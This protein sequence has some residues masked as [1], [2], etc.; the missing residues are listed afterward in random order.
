MSFILDALKKSESER[1]R[2]VGPSL[3]DVRVVRR[4]NSERPWWVIAVAALL[5]VNLGVLL[6]VLIRGWSAKPDTTIQQAAAA[7]QSYSQPGYNGPPPTQAPQQS[8]NAGPQ[9][10]PNYAGQPARQYQQPPARQAYQPNPV[11]T[12][13]SVRS[14]ADEAG[15]YQEPYP[16]ESLSPHLA[17]AARVPEGAPM[18]RQIEPPAVAPLPSG[19]VLAAKTAAN[20]PPR[21]ALV[22]DETL[23]TLEDLS[24]SGTNLPELHLDIHVASQNPAE[25]FVFVNMRKYLEGETLKEG[26]S[27]E[28]I[29]TEGVILNQ[30]GLRFLLPRQ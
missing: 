23:P 11:P 26:P 5:V 29:T 16:D 7:Q 10:A 13:P 8:Y 24:A 19:A 22:G 21:G 27:V 18:V 17:G 12:D 3:A 6:V 20:A 14:L 15:A 25:R 30:R 2:Q 4:S 1:Q 28:R 9:Y